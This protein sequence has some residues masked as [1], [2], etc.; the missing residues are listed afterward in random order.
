MYEYF[1]KSINTNSCNLLCKLT[2]SLYGLKQSSHAWYQHFDNFLAQQ[3][4]TR[5]QFD[6]NIYV[7]R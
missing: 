4:F 3:G 2:K 1:R 5:L 6:A 7:K